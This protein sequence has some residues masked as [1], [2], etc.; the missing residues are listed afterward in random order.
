MTIN[1]GTTNVDVFHITNQGGGSSV[2]PD[3]FWFPT[4]I[5]AL[6]NGLSKIDFFGN[7]ASYNANSQNEFSVAGEYDSVDIT[8]MDGNLRTYR[9]STGRCFFVLP[10]AYKITKFAVQ[11]C[12][13]NPYTNGIQLF[14]DTAA[15][16]TGVCDLLATCNTRYEAE[17]RGLSDYDWIVIDCDH[18]DKTYRYLNTY[19]NGPI[20]NIKFYC[21]SVD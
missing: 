11:Y 16:Q 3:K 2:V 13:A 20:L 8:M 5:L 1:I 9:T 6:N 7:G 10:K 18:T 21:E 19:Q 12:S 15:M 14:G 4:D 17:Q